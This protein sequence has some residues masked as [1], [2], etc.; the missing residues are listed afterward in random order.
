MHYRSLLMLKKTH[1]N[2]P[3]MA[4]WDTYNETP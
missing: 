1:L 3:L 4:D 2:E